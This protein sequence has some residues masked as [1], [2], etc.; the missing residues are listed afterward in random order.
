MTKT[1]RAPE[2]Y[3]KIMVKALTGQAIGCV[4]IRINPP[5]R[6]N[7]NYIF[8]GKTT[9]TTK[10]TGVKNPALR[11]LPDFLRV[12]ATDWS[13][14]G[15]ID[16]MVLQEDGRGL[17]VMEEYP[18]HYHET[19]TKKYKMGWERLS[20]DFYDG[21]EPIVRA[22]RGQPV[23][24]EKHYVSVVGFGTIQDFIS[25]IPYENIGGGSMGRNFV[26]FSETA[27]FKPRTKR[28]NQDLWEEDFL[29]SWLFA[30]CKNTPSEFLPTDA[31]IKR[32]AELE[33]KSEEQMEKYGDDDYISIY[34][35]YSKDYTVKHAAIDTIMDIPSDGLGKLKGK[36]IELQ[37]SYLE[38]AWKLVEQIFQSSWDNVFI[39]LA[40]TDLDFIYRWIGILGKRHPEIKIHDVNGWAPRRQLMQN[41][42]KRIKGNK[43][44]FQD[45]LD[46]LND[47]EWIVK[48][49]INPKGGGRTGRYYK[50]VKDKPDVLKKIWQARD[51]AAKAK[52]KE[53]KQQ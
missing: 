17:I 1:Y 7:G 34:G 16:A 28:S 23:T 20:I 42:Y 31:F 45:I 18:K 10:S 38:K 30:I 49:F 50:A 22:L 14:E 43:K 46:F 27:P 19:M 26:I 40:N 37:V 35:R 3:Q 9:F 32:L 8:L 47:E 11:V 39:H 12:M 29:K 2:I 51:E 21:N 4:P 5:L 48:G 6:C 41:T 36:T 24:L 33:I 52:R 13:T 25:M 53:V 15:L 44:R